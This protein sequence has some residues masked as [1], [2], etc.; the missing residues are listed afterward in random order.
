MHTRYNNQAKLRHYKKV[1]AVQARYQEVK[2]E[3]MTLKYIHYH[4]ISTEFFIGYST[5]YR[6][7]DIN[8]KRHITQLE[9]LIEDEKEG[10]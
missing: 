9:K 7:L 4:Y 3:H 5:F 1:L 6:Y 2:K 10:S 8:A